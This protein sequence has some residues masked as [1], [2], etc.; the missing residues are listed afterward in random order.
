MQWGVRPGR[1]TPAKVL[2]SLTICP[3]AHWDAVRR[4]AADLQQMAVEN[5]VEK[6]WITPANRAVIVENSVENPVEN[7]GG[8]S[9]RPM[10][11]PLVLWLRLALGLLMEM[12]LGL[13]LVLRLG[14]LLVLQLLL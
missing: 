5:L 3:A 8:G 12:T 9:A 7:R 11:L 2:T 13:L 1:Q 4:R 14:L 6:L 10:A